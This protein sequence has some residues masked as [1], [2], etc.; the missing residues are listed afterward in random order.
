M[1]FPDNCI[2]LIGVYRVKREYDPE[3]TKK[4]NS[5][6]TPALIKPFLKPTRILKLYEPE[7]EIS[8]VEKVIS[9][10]KS[11]INVQNLNF[12]KSKYEEI[13]SEITFGR[14]IINLLLRSY[15]KFV[16]TPDFQ[17]EKY[18]KLFWS[19]VNLESYGFINP[20]ETSKTS[21]VMNKQEFFKHFLE[22]CQDSLPPDISGL[23]NNILQDRLSHYYNN[24]ENFLNGYSHFGRMQLVS[25]PNPNELIQYYNWQAIETVICNSTDSILITQTFSGSDF[26][27]MFYK[28]RFSR[29]NYE[30]YSRPWESDLIFIMFNRGYRLFNANDKTSRFLSRALLKHI[31]PNLLENNAPFILINLMKSRGNEVVVHFLPEDFKNAKTIVE[32]PQRNE[33]R[34]YSEDEAEYDEISDDDGENLEGIRSVNDKKEDFGKEEESIIDDVTTEDDFDSEIEA[35][36][37]K[38]FKI[39]MGSDWS[40]MREPDL[41]STKS[42][43]LMV[44]DFVITNSVTKIYIEIVG[45]WTA[46]YIKNKI[47]KI[48]ELHKEEIPPFIFI[49]DG[50]LK[51]YFKELRITNKNIHFIYYKQNKLDKA[52]LELKEMINKHFSALSINQ[53]LIES[54]LFSKR[55][56][57]T[58]ELQMEQQTMIKMKNLYNDLKILICELIEPAGVVKPDQIPDQEIEKYIFSQN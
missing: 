57:E 21:D 44:P 25:E 4:I 48:G 40:I 42:G 12:D 19:T 26:K 18:R 39:C 34:Y 14:G 30:I 31:I 1:T 7:N 13:F 24:I 38:Y 46:K 27:K 2:D 37:D 6:E 15:F 28:L 8:N 3:L 23:E 35:E 9:E 36:F 20:F 56:W 41:I 22:N 17:A 32:D 33:N 16:S 52:V 5:E 51:K 50:D 43:R 53:D 10:L 47:I 11:E 58:V 29:V 55:I 54:I 45:F 49:I